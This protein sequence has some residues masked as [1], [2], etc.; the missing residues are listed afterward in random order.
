[1]GVSTIIL[2][3]LAGVLLLGVLPTLLLSGI[4]FN[5][6]SPGGEMIKSILY[7]FHLPIIE[8]ID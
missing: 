6:F 5:R 8:T 7:F 3:C 1:M 2:L 4:I